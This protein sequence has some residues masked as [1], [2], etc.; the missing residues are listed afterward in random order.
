MLLLSSISLYFI[1]IFSSHSSNRQV[2]PTWTQVPRL[3]PDLPW[4]SEP[5]RV[6]TSVWPRLRGCQNHS[7]PHVQET[8]ALSENCLPQTNFPSLEMIKQWPLTHPFPVFIP[9]VCCFLSNETT[10]GEFSRTPENL[11]LKTKVTK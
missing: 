1:L 5:S 6:W 8:L 10:L 11:L 9:A 3:S 4:R 7:N 2:A